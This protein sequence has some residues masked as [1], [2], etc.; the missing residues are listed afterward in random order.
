M[1]EPDQSVLVATA[2]D[3]PRLQ[4]CL[5]ALRAQ[6]DAVAGGELV[7]VFNRERAEV[8]D[9]AARAEAIADRVVFEAAPGK[10]RALNRG[11]AACRGAVIAFTDDDAELERRGLEALAGAKLAPGGQAQGLGGRAPEE[12]HY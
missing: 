2:G 7:V 3:T 12:P 6:V 4:G 1:A 10:S 9:D 11:I 8:A 5:A